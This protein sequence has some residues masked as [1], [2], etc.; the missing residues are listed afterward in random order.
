M[1]GVVVPGWVWGYG[2][3][4]VWGMAMGYGVWPGISRIGLGFAV[5]ASDLPVLALLASD[6]PV[7]ALLA[8]IL[9]NMAVLASILTNMAVL[10]SIWLNL[11]SFGLN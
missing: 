10:A 2:H 3:G 5:L 7:L 4:V 1:H 9:T 8:S 6:L 11:T